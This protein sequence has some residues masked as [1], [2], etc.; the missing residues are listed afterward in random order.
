M[1]KVTVTFEV[2]DKSTSEAGV[3]I[4][5]GSRPNGMN[6]MECS[7]DRRESVKLEVIEK[8]ESI[9]SSEEPAM[10]IPKQ[11][12][13]DDIT[14]SVFGSCFEDSDEYIAIEEELNTDAFLQDIDTSKA[15]YSRGDIVEAMPTERKQLHANFFTKLQ[16]GDY[17]EENILV[18]QE[19]LTTKARLFY[20]DKFTLVKVRNALDRVHGKH[21]R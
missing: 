1:S 13:F 18:Q 4:F 10:C 15:C 8:K 20:L 7:F 14:P 21:K 11:G 9:T 6:I 17:G 19:R 3:L 5:L 16:N 12:T 2:D